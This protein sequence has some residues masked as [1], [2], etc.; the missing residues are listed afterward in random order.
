M[1]TNIPRHIAIIP[2]GNRRWAKK[3]G[4]SSIFGH[5]KGAKTAEEIINAAMNLGVE[6][7]TLWGCSVDNITKRDDKEVGFL[8][9][10][11]EKY[12]KRLLADKKIYK[13][14]VRVEM[15]GKWRNYFPKSGIAVMDELIK[16]TKKHSK[17]HM[18]FLMAYSG[19]DEMVSAVRSISSG[20]PEDIDADTIKQNLFTK[21]LPP[22]DLV[23]RTG[24]EPHWSSGFMMWDVRDAQLYFTKTL[25]PA[26]SVKE[27]KEAIG[28]Y[29][30]TE[31][32]LGK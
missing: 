29:S 32:R 22:V 8:F 6:Y 19:V 5:R 2:D 15:L 11:F 26:F 21:D 20:K 17:R 3:R 16:K 23:I 13:N 28:S 25:W 4:L 27:L 12:F 24:G 31:R 30:A 10:V 18:T 9:R 1:E 7:V 14:E